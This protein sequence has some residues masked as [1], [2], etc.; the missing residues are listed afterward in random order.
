MNTILVMPREGRLVSR[1]E[2]NVWLGQVPQHILCCNCFNFHVITPFP[3]RFT[4][5]HLGYVAYV[6]TAIRAIAQVTYDCSQLVLIVRIEVR[7]GCGGR[8]RVAGRGRHA[9]IAPIIIKYRV[10]RDIFTGFAGR[11][12]RGVVGIQRGTSQTFPFFI[13]NLSSPTR[14][15]CIGGLAIVY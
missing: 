4:I 3:H 9:N 1:V 13:L 6:V 11:A 2:Q 7:L 12:D 15:D 10:I 8:H 5:L 14:T